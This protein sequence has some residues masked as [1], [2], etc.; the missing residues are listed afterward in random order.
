[1]ARGRCSRLC[2]LSELRGEAFV[3]HQIGGRRPAL[4]S[5]LSNEGDGPI[6][7]VRRCTAWAIRRVIWL[8]ASRR[9]SVAGVGAWAFLP[10]RGGA[11][12]HAGIVVGAQLVAR[13]G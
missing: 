2:H 4:G 10:T 1:M 6:G 3:G 5:P 13:A 8:T 7:R 9:S 12:R 11:P